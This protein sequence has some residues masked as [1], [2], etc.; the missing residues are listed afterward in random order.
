MTALDW[1]KFLPGWFAAV[2]AAWTLF[3]KWQTRRHRRALGPDDDALR[4]Q[5]ALLRRLFKEI[6]EQGR[7]K[8]WFRPDDRSDLDG[9]LLDLAFRRTDTALQTYVS[10]AA[11]AWRRARLNAPPAPGPSIRRAGDRATPKERAQTEKER[12]RFRIQRECAERGLLAISE[13]LNRLNEL[14]EPTIGR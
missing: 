5:L 8:E 4:A 2:V 14:E 11:L 7:R 9:T 1:I 3:D 12:Q 13:A 6:C 10:D